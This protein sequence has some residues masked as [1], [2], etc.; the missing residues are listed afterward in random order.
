MF[1]LKSMPSVTKIFI[2]CSLSQFNITLF[3]LQFSF[4]LYPMT[5]ECYVV[6]VVV[7]P[8]SMLCWKCKVD[9]HVT[10]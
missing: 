8:M 4:S 3:S 5:K 10:F 9:T 6:V 7:V 2:P 1:D